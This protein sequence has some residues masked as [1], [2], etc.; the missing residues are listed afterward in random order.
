MVA[1]GTREGIESLAYD[2]AVGDPHT[3]EE[4]TEKKTGVLFGLLPLAAQATK[5][6]RVPS[7]VEVGVLR[8][9]GR[10]G[11]ASTNWGLGF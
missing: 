6:V 4:L 9:P 5:N 11:Q 2:S 3:G 8:R 1:N 10:A 7:F